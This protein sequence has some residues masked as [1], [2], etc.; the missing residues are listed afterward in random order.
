MSK[1]YS[2]GGVS[3]AISFGA[4]V[5]DYAFTGKEGKGTVTVSMATEKTTH[6]LAADGGVMVS[7]VLG[8]NGG[9]S[10][11]MQ[12]TSDLHAFLLGAYNALKTTAD[13]GDPGEWASGALSIRSLVDGAWHSLSGVSF[14]K[15]PDK[16]YASQGGKVTWALMAAQ[17]QSGVN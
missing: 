2:F 1:T 10:M 17:V 6:D 4:G 16:A 8:D 9:A 15:I 14:S 3:L 13:A 11:E 7:Y 12:Q 5:G